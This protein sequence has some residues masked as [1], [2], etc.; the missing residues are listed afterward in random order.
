MA[1]TDIMGLGLPCLDYFTIKHG[2]LFILKDL[3]W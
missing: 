2:A 1:R 3:F